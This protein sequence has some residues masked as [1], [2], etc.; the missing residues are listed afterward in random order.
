MNERDSFFLQ[1]RRRFLR[2][3]ACGLG[4]IALAD[5][6]AREGRTAGTAQV[7]NPLWPRPPH[8]TPRAKSVIFLFMAGAPSQLDLFDP[9]LVLQKLHGQPVP[10]SFL[11]GLADPVIKGGAT[12][13]ASPRTFRK[14]GRCSMDFS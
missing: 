9:K 14:Y 1:Q 5:L 10:E 2:Q 7:V 3:S 13:M 11:K 12:V 4:T 6:L 8:F